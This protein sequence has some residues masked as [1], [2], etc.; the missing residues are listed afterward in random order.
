MNEDGQ[1]ALLRHARELAQILGYQ[2]EH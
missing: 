1:D 2:K